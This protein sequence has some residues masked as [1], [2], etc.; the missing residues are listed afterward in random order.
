MGMYFDL[1]TTADTLIQTMVNRHLEAK[2]AN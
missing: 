2:R 1:E